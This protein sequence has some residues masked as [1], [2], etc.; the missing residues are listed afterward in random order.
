[1]TNSLY[2]IIN[3]I[4]ILS[5]NDHQTLINS[6]SVHITLLKPMILMIKSVN[7]FFFTHKLSFTFSSTIQMAVLWKHLN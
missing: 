3:F 7:I 1:M 2:D 6:T 5:N 4:I